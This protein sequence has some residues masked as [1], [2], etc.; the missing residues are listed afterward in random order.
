MAQ[1]TTRSAQSG[2]GERIEHQRSLDAG[3]AQGLEVLDAGV[4]EPRHAAAKHRVRHLWRAQGGLGDAGDGDAALAEA[5]DQFFGVV[6][7][8]REVD[9]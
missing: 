1:A 6:L 7:D 5:S 3:L 8:R 4:A 9:L 2:A